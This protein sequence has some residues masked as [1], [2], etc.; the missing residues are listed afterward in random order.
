MYAYHC[1]SLC[2][3]WQGKICAKIQGAPARLTIGKYKHNIRHGHAAKAACSFATKTNKRK[4]LVMDRS[5]TNKND[6]QGDERS[7]SESLKVIDSIKPGMTPAEQVAILRH[8]ITCINMWY[9]IKNLGV[10]RMEEHFADQIG[11]SFTHNAKLALSGHHYHRMRAIRLIDDIS[12]Y[13]TGMWVRNVYKNTSLYLTEDCLILGL[14]SDHR[15]TDAV[16]QSD[17]AC[18]SLVSDQFLVHLMSLDDEVCGQGN[19]ALVSNALK[20][21]E[22]VLFNVKINAQRKADKIGRVENI[23][24]IFSRRFDNCLSASKPNIAAKT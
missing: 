3:F 13:H 21:L 9:P 6:P 8:S 24:G 16:E 12:N 23:V 22:M 11:D 4:A 15:Q 19:K 7:I 20:S 2:F 17:T 18:V 5:N 1:R 10:K 14:Q